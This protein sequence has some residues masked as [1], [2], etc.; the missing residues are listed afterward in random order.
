MKTFKQ[1]REEWTN[2]YKKDIDCSN[3]NC[4]GIRRLGGN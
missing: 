1:F 3:P 4:C 2:K